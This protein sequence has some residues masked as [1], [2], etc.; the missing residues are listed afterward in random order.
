M[1]RLLVNRVNR[2]QRRGKEMGVWGKKLG[3]LVLPP[4][5]CE[6]GRKPLAVFGHWPNDRMLFQPRK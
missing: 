6:R 1:G 4:V 5:P 2:E 3:P